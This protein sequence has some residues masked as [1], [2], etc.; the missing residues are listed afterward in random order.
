MATYDGMILRERDYVLSRANQKGSEEE[1]EAAD[2][3]ALPYEEAGGPGGE[4]PYAE[5]PGGPQGDGGMDSDDGTQNS[6]SGG[7]YRPE[8]GANRQGD[9]QHGGGGAPPPADIPDGS[10][11]D[12]VARQ[13]REA[14]MQE[15][16]P[17][18]REKLWNEYR[19]YK[20]QQSK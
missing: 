5:G 16:D 6:S 3:G 13:I 12:V 17:E 4:E 1:L 11:D 8:G 20:S 2:E 15:T 10:D 14:A 18:L 19:K 9:Y 7:G